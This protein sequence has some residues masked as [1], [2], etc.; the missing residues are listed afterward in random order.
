MKTNIPVLSFLVAIL[1]LTLSCTQNRESHKNPPNIVFIMAD[2]MGWSDVGYNGAPYETAN[3]DEIAEQGLV[4]TRFYP[5]AANCAPSRASI[6]TGMYAPRHKVYIPQGLSRGGDLSRMRFKTPAWNADSSY[7]NTFDV[8]INQVD[9]S[10]VSLAEQLK[11]AGYVTARFGKWH[12]GGDNQGFDVNSATGPVGE[13]TNRTVDH[14][15]AKNLKI[16]GGKEERYYADTTVAANLTNAAIQFIKENHNSPFFLY[17]S[18]WE[19][20]TPLAAKTERIHYYK[21]KFAGKKPEIDPVYAAE[22]EQVDRSVGKILEV[23]DELH[24]TENTLVIF[25][26]DNGGVSNYT[27][28]KP[29]RAGKGTFYEGGIR[30]PFC[31]RWPKVIKPGLKTGIPVSGIDLMPTF[32]EL[33]G[34]SLPDNQPVDGI[35]LLPLF[36]GKQSGSNRSIYFHFP[37]YLRGGGIDRVL[38]AWDGSENYWR[39]VPLSVIVKDDWKLIYYYE[40]DT[41][42]LFNVVVDISESHDLSAIEADKAEVLLADLMAWVKEVGA[43]VPDKE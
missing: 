2:D 15:V 36:E 14:Q 16:Q 24:L 9:S 5:S 18:H 30:T 20:H 41:F 22:V 28:N 13:T 21:N 17:L 7:F 3:I 40:Y 25:T 43:A 37:L 8:S 26:S 38:P 4:C 19:V 33:S 11:K 23:L 39:A 27:S 1:F 34:T 31:A 32:A 10:F 29:L 6:L 35:S 12:I 42:E